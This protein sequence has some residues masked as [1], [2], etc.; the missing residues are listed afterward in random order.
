MTDCAQGDPARYLKEKPDGGVIPV[1]PNHVYEDVVLK[2][3][4]W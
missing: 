4:G 3:G 2:K 1:G